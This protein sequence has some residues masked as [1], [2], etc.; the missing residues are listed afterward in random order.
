VTSIVAAAECAVESVT[1]Q[2]AYPVLCPGHFE[3]GSAIG[4]ELPC[5]QNAGSP[6]GFTDILRLFLVCGWITGKLELR[7]C[8]KSSDSLNFV[9]HDAAQDEVLV[10]LS[11]RQIRNYAGF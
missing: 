7:L 5:R 2:S 1:S 11:L 4:T 6:E 9:K 8:R 10:I 3:V